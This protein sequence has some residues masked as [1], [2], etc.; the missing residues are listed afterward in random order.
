MIAQRLL[1]IKK[2]IILLY[3]IIGYIYVQCTPFRHCI[4][5]Q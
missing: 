1:A 2:Y 4:Y 3:H 5:M